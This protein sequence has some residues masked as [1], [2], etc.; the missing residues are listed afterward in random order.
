[1]PKCRPMIDY[2]GSK[3]MPLR[4]R[5]TE[6]PDDEAAG[7]LDLAPLFEEGEP[8]EIRPAPNEDCKEA[9]LAIG[10]D[11]SFEEPVEVPKV[12]NF[13]P[14]RINSFASS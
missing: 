3:E 2:E 4:Y 11:E 6:A 10:D 12:K 5:G 1:M 7:D 14:R 13:L 8:G 9:L